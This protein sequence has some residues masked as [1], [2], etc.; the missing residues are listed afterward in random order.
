MIEN[1]TKIDELLTKLR[2]G[3]NSALGLLY[4][5]TNK[6]LYVLCYSYFGGREDSEDALSDTYLKVFENRHKFK[7]SNGFNWMYTIAIN[8]CKNKL[9]MQNKVI[10]FDLNN[11]NIIN[12]LSDNNQIAVQDENGIIELSKKIL[13]NTEF[14]ILLLHAVNEYKFKE[15]AEIMNM[16]ESTVRWKFNNAIKKIQKEYKRRYGND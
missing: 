13:D 15:I 5:L 4:D 6:Q 16:V 3:D 7:G 14:R 10:K 1:A 11:Q 2:Q 12:K 9:K 8:I